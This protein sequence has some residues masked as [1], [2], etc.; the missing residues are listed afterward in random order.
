MYSKAQIEE[1]VRKVLL[2]QTPLTCTECMRITN[3][4]LK[5][6]ESP[7]DIFDLD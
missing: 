6:L 2:D 4:V 5:E 1:V 3:E 7:I